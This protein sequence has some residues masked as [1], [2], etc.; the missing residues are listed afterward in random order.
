M[1]V[2]IV[3]T[4]MDLKEYQ[5]FHIKTV[6]K[7]FSLLYFAVGLGGECGEVLNEVKKVYRKDE[8][9]SEEDR[10]KLI[11]ELGDV[12]WYVTAISKKLDVSLEEVLQSNATKLIKRNE[13][14]N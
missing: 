14:K 11:L 2:S 12:V 4:N 8:Q 9:V 3:N 6:Q 1:I 5:E 13:E 10:Q 7:D